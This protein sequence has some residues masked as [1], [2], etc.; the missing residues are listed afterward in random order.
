MSAKKLICYDPLCEIHNSERAEKIN[1]VTDAS[2]ASVRHLI[3]PTVKRMSEINV[4]ELRIRIEG[5]KVLFVMLP[6]VK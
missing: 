3:A 1:W 2:D 6:L 5:K 4:G